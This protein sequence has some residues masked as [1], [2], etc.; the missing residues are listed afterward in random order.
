[1][2]AQPHRSMMSVADYLTL[3]RH[4]TDQRYEY[5]DGQVYLLAGGSPAHARIASTLIRE[6]GVHLRGGPCDVYTSDVY[7]RL[8]E[9]RYV[10]PDVTV[11]CDER[12]RLP[13]TEMLDSPRLV[14]EVLSPSSEVFDRRKKF[15]LY[16]GV[17]SI[18]EYVLVNTEEPLVEVY[19]RE[20][21]HAFWRYASFGPGEHVLFSSLGVSIPVETIY[22]HVTFPEDGES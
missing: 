22:E 21:D 16:R 5:I 2:V 9:N 19:R 1:M 7:V 8:S 14:I 15:G 10:H 13:D 11:S 18:Q 3:D 6:L 4:S 12:D 17:S 20:Q